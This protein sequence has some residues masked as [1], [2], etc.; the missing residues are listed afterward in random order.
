MAINISIRD[1]I[2]PDFADMITTQMT[3]ANV[4][5]E[6]L[7]LEITER[8]LMDDRTG[9]VRAADV[10]TATGVQLSIDDFGTGH[11]SL[12]RLHQLPVTELKIDRSFVAR[13][14]ADPE[15]EIIVKSIIELGRSLGHQVT[16]EGIER[17]SEVQ[18]L[19]NLGCQV[20]QGY[21]YSA[22]IPGD[23]FIQLLEATPNTPPR[24]TRSHVRPPG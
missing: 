21:L 6:Q 23:Q 19:R 12:L 9:F 24:L 2:D 15:A 11:S 13:L 1:L 8:D 18:A 22:A 7:I 20:G 3:K 16:A 4:S 10:I 17:V 5:P 14:G